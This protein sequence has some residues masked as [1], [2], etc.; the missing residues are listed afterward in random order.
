MTDLAELLAT[1]AEEIDPADP[2]ELERHDLGGGS[3]YRRS[4]RP[5]AVAR[6]E[7][8][9]VRLRPDVAEAARRTPDAIL[10]ERG[11]EWV[12]FTP[13]KLDRYALDRATSW[14][15]FAWRHAVE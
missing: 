14:F 11:P 4:G 7:S 13:A 8:I 2:Q 1:L 10:S 5:F 9:D 12:T 15:E 6:P 3:E